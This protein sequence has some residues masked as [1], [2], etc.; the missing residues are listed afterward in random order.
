MKKNILYIAMACIALGF[1]ACSDDP[2]DAVSKHV[3]GPDESP[4]LRADADAT[5]SLNAEFR[6][7]HVTPKT[8][9]LKDYAEQIQTKMKMTVDDMLA[10]IESGKVAFHS[11]NTARGIWD[12]SAMTK[13]DGWWYNNNGAVVGNDGVAS[14]ELDKAAKALVLNVPEGSAAGLSMAANVGFAVVNGKDYDQYVRFTVNFSITDPGTIIQDIIIPAGDYAS[15][16]FDLTSIENA[17]NACFGMTSADFIATIAST[18]NDIAMYLADDNGNWDTSSGYTAGGIGLWV[19]VD[20]KVCNWSGNGY[21]AGN[22]Y[23][24][25]THADDKTVGIGRAP[26]VPSGTKAKVH[27]V[28]ASKSDATR[29]IEFVLNAT[30]E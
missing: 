23:Y 22:F 24:I 8:V 30:F 27:F 15:Y 13:G 3:Y 29:F 20:H 10:G 18:E 6:K 21:A 19:D 12:M 16:E 26:G 4:Y 1:T 5:I 7:G 9:Y 25:E 14:I 17:I 28:Y 2:E 11:I